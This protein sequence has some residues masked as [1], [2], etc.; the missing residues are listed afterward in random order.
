M[1]LK[2]GPDSY[3][4]TSKGPDL[5][6]GRSAAS[7]LRV[8][9]QRYCPPFPGGRH[10]QAWS[11][12]AGSGIRCCPRWRLVALQVVQPA[13]A[14]ARDQ[15]SSVRKHYPGKR[16]SHLPPGT[17]PVHPHKREGQPRQA[18]TVGE[19]HALP[20]QWACTLQARL[21][22]RA[23]AR[24]LLR[25]MSCGKAGRKRRQAPAPPSFS[26]TSPPSGAPKDSMG[27]LQ[28]ACP[29]LKLS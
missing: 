14:A 9:P 17:A 24:Q 25:I 10:R 22:P 5:L 23:R 29:G 20:L 15:A 4:W 19:R 11:A 16:T 27:V 8:C 3:Y 28:G 12:L 13:C 7:C 18:R 2:L 21:P 6:S 26:P 1:T